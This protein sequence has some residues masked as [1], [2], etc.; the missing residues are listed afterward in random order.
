MRCC[1]AK[2]HCDREDLCWR[3]GLPR[4]GA[5]P[6]GEAPVCFRGVEKLW[7]WGEVEQRSL[8]RGSR[9]AAL[10]I[11]R[12]T[13][14]AD[15]NQRLRRLLRLEQALPGNN[16][17]L[18][19]SLTS[20]LGG[21]RATSRIVMNSGSL[22]GALQS[23]PDNLTEQFKTALADHVP[24][25]VLPSV[26]NMLTADERA[27]VAS[28][29]SAFRVYNFLSNAAYVRY[30]AS[31]RSMISTREV[32][33]FLME[34]CA[35]LLATEVEGVLRKIR[36]VVRRYKNPGDVTKHAFG[37]YYAI[38]AGLKRWN[39]ESALDIVLSPLKLRASM[40]IKDL[41]LLYRD[42]YGARETLQ[43]FANSKI[44]VM[45]EIH[46][47]HLS[48]ELSAIDNPTSWNMISDPFHKEFSVNLSVLLVRGGKFRW[49]QERHPVQRGVP[50]PGRIESADNGPLQRGRSQASESR[51]LRPLHESPDATL[52]NSS[53]DDC[54]TY[55][56]S[57]TE[58]EHGAELR[59]ENPVQAGDVKTPQDLV[60]ISGNTGNYPKR[61]RSPASPQYTSL[62]PPTKRSELD[63]GQAFLGNLD[64]HFDDAYDILMEAREISSLQFQDDIFD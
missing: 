33:C 61:G 59:H 51:S 42:I 13:T 8:D 40:V 6:T 55:I 43:D 48:H 7:L 25:L 54:S 29:Q 32:S 5:N 17:S 56:H 15:S 26:P 22:A 31:A 35:R 46:N 30:H 1:L 53:W 21:S 58:A 44:P 24:D 9:D 14:F 10:D 37:I 36:S 38:L 23:R 50:S 28:T 63:A 18:M 4:P 41:G 64:H 47:L 16:M 34:Y 62:S 11:A 49:F 45:T 3:C 2:K 60:G 12:N 57:P 39:T 52:R 20:K 19:V 27:L